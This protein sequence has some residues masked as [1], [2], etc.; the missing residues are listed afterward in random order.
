MAS[1]IYLL[2]FSIKVLA[3]FYM[4]Q[5]Y[6]IYTNCYIYLILTVT[7]TC[8]INYTKKTLRRRDRYKV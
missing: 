8:S 3:Q 5:N 7:S 6:C 1:N 2:T 4:V